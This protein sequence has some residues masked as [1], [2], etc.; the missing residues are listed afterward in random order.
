VVMHQKLQV[1]WLR[2]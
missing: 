1:H 2:I